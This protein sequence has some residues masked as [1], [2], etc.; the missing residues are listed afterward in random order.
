MSDEIRDNEIAREGERLNMV[1][2]DDLG[3]DEVQTVVMAQLSSA[4]KP[5]NT[6]KR[7]VDWTCSPTPPTP[8]DVRS[9]PI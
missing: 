9:R 6:A 4:A 1:E 8:G 7:Q 5:N 3:P 2:K